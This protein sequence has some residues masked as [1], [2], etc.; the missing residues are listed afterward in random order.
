[1]I[2]VH[3]HGDLGQLHDDEKIKIDVESPQ[4]AVDFLSCVLPGF[5]KKITTGSYYLSRGNTDKRLD[6]SLYQ[7]NFGRCREMHIY[8]DPTGRKIGGAPV[9]APASSDYEFRDSEDVSALFNGGVNTT[10]QGIC[11]PIIYGRATK[12]G[13]AVVSAGISV[14]DVG[15]S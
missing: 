10:E 5:K 15:V 2:T 11:V 14:E 7:L 9:T 6:E 8:P 4:E 1:M 13:S 12:A 3:F